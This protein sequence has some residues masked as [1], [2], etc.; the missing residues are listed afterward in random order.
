M[1]PDP[2]QAHIEFQNP[3]QMHCSQN[4]DQR[5]IK[6]GYLPVGSWSSSFKPEPAFHGKNIRAKQSSFY[7]GSALIIPESV[8]CLI[9]ASL[10]LS[11]SCCCASTSVPLAWLSAMNPKAGMQFMRYRQ[12]FKKNKVFSQ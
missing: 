12:Q 2:V 4:W 8:G 5:K 7:F 11:S 10:C 3:N 9:H 1:L 6:S